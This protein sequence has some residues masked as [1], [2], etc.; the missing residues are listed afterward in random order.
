MV[1]PV[2]GQDVPV[3]VDRDPLQA[4]EL[5]GAGAPLAEAAQVGAV[6]VED[7]QDGFGSFVKK[8]SVFIAKLGGKNSP[9]SCCFRCPLRRCT[10]ARPQP[11]PCMNMRRKNGLEFRRT[12]FPSCRINT[13]QVSIVP[14]ELELPLPRPL[15]PEGGDDLSVDVE[16][17]DPVVVRVGDDDAVG[18]ADG[19]VVRVLKVPWAGAH[20]AE[21][22]HEGAVGL[23]NLPKEKYV[24]V[25][26]NKLC[27]PQK[28]AQS[29][30]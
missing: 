29:V 9:V 3:G 18:V 7:L 25:N 5:R 15:L 27:S 23:E 4:L 28:C 17:L 22:A 26:K 19:D 1:L 11:P 20:L 14:R 12:V 10:P 2:R 24:L 13:K 6:R 16:D 21:L 30:P 8:M